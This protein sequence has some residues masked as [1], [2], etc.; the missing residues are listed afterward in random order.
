MKAK[1]SSQSLCRRIVFSLMLICLVSMGANAQNPKPFVVPELQE[2]DGKTGSFIPGENPRVVYDNPILQ[3]IANRFA[4]DYKLMFGVQPAVLKGKPQ[5]GDFFL[6][7]K[8]DKKLAN[9]GYVIDINKYVKVS[10]PEP[11]GVY[12]ATRTLLQMSEKDKVQ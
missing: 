6:T 1:K 7:T 10:A 4:E 12:W 9:E 11:I 8:K 2:W 5:E 3:D